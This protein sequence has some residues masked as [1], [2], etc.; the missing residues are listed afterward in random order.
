MFKKFKE[1]HACDIVGELIE[2]N[3]KIFNSPNL[4]FWELDLAVDDL[5]DANIAFARQVFQHL[6]NDLIEESIRKIEKKYEYLVL[7]E[8]IPKKEDCVKNIDKPPGSHTR[9]NVGSCIDLKV[10]P[11]NLKF[12]TCLELCSVSYGEGLIQTQIFKLIP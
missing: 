3:K 4:K 2:R 11:F 1:Y 7:T 10:S 9:M 5:P 12:E 8:H 6:S